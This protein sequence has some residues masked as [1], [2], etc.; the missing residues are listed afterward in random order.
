MM[1]VNGEVLTTE[2]RRARYQT[3]LSNTALAR[4][5]SSAARP[6]R[7]SGPPI[8]PPEALGRKSRQVDNLISASCFLSPFRAERGHLPAATLVGPLEARRKRKSR[9]LEAKGGKQEDMYKHVY[10]WTYFRHGQA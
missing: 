9:P 5:C 8:A 4:A 2:S 10:F 1:I 7:D 6:T 3:H